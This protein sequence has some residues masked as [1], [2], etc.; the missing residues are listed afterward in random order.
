MESEVRRR[1]WFDRTCVAVRMCFVLGKPTD[2]CFPFL[3]RT[4][5]RQTLTGTTDVIKVVDFVLATSVYPPEDK[6]NACQ[7]NK[8]TDASNDTSNDFLG[9]G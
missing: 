4:A 8:S 9:R 2:I 5:I 7:E 6:G 1:I 3:T